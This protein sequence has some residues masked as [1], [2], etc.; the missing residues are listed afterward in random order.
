MSAQLKFRFL[1]FLRSDNGARTEISEYIL[2]FNFWFFNLKKL[3]KKIKLR[4]RQAI[5]VPNCSHWAV[6]QVIGQAW[7]NLACHCETTLPWLDFFFNAMRIY[8]GRRLY[9]LFSLNFAGP[10]FD[11]IRRENR[12]GVMFVSREHAEIFKIVADIYIDAKM[13][14]GSLE[15]SQLYLLKMKPRWGFGCL[16]RLGEILCWVFVDL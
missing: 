8:G 7:N 1:Q 3:L 15:L 5:R 16:G 11:N 12:K 9:D 10:S 2:I 13:R 14:L 6:F 4:F